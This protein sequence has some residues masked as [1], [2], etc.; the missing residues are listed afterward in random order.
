M[1]ETG[2]VIPV[3]SNAIIATPITLYR[4]NCKV[5]NATSFFYSS[6]NK[7]YLVSNRHVF[8][9]EENEFFPD[10]A[11]IKVHITMTDL[12]KNRLIDLPLMDGEKKLWLE[13]RDKSIDLALLD[14]T[15]IVEK[16]W[17][18]RSLS[19]TD[20]PTADKLFPL[21]QEVVIV[22]YPRGFHDTNLNFP[23]VRKG[24]IA[25]LYGANFQK[26]PYFLVDAKLHPGT[27]GSPVL[28]MPSPIQLTN[29]G[30]NIGQMNSFFLGINSGE[31]GD[32]QLNAI[33]Y[34]GL[35]DAIIAKEI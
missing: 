16:D 11:T 12:E 25:S 9:K 14:I 24:S 19:K 34:P 26:N 18:F 5:S 23:I 1:A 8:V 30:M 7:T 3:D 15:A 31:H 17:V 29:Q 13:A 32:L 28:S 21:G 4:G 20:F 35:L 2:P 10:H 33:W 6:N 27:S 22:G